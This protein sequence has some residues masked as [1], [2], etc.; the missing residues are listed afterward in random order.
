MKTDPNFRLVMME[1]SD[2]TF[3]THANQRMVV[4]VVRDHLGQQQQPAMSWGAIAARV[5]TT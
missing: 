3:S 5:A 1:H 4:D 2:H